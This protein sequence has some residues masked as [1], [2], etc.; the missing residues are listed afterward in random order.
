MDGFQS[1][2]TGYRVVARYEGHVQESSDTLELTSDGTETVDL[3]LRGSLS[4]AGVVLDPDGNLLPDAQVTITG[5]SGLSSGHEYE[6]TATTDVGGRFELDGL[7]LGVYLLVATA[8]G[9]NEASAVASAGETD[10]ELKLSLA[11]SVHVHLQAARGANDAGAVEVRLERDGRFIA[12]E[13]ADERGD[14]YFEDI[15]PGPVTVNVFR[16]ALPS[17]IPWWA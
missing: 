1:M 6:R 3:T 9:F 12:Y 15:V 13:I 2:Q 17:C 16:A 8:P 10:A 7:D 11:G 5:R 14:A 4:L